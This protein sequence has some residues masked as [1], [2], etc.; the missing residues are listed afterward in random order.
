[1]SFG[2]EKMRS[3][4]IKKGKI[5]KKKKKGEEKE[6]WEVKRSNKCQIGKNKSEKAQKE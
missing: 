6:K 2:G 5:G 3:G 4:K 1:M